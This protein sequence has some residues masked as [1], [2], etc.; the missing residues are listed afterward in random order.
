MTAVLDTNILM[1]LVTDDHDTQSPA[2]RRMLV[3]SPEP[4]LVAAATVSEVVFVLASR[5]YRFTRA[6]TVDVLERLLGVPTLTFLDRPV[7]EQA[8][9]IFRDHHDDWDDCLVAAYAFEHAGGRVAS[10]DKGLDGIPG[11]T[12]AVPAAGA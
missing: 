6:R 10:F 3:D 8:I 12:R 7:I 5:T 9:R 1:R 2:V 4:Y 11:L